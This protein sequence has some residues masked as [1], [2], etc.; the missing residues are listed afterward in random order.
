MALKIGLIGI[1]G[2][3]LGEDPWGTLQRVAEVGYEG[4]EGAAS[5]A[6]RV[7]RSVPEMKAK[8]DALG[9]K[10]PAQGSV[11]LESTDDEIAQTIANARAIGTS[12]VVQYWGPCESEEQLL[13]EA[14]FLNRVGRRCAEAGLRFC[15]HNHNHEFAEFGGKRAVDILME[16]TD[17]D[18]V[19]LELDVAWCT[20]GGVDPATM[21]RKYAGRCP[22]LHIKDLAEVPPGGATSNDGRK[23]T[24]FTEVG[25]GVVDLRG[26]VEAARECGVDWL[27]VEQDRMRDL[28]P[29]E[30][31]KVSYDNLKAIVG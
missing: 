18:A 12:C 20:F 30:S 6:S 19:N 11:R 7:G 31:M 29:M 22:V 21:I 25:T 8:L 5:M 4:I 23:E 28:P 16:N 9:L 27:V 13:Q 14:E 1:V 10:V 26:T 15:Y 3:E 2:K 24:L 17:P